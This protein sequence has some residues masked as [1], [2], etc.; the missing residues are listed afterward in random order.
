M[1]FSNVV[2]LCKNWYETRA[3]ER[4]E[5]FW[6]DLA[7]AADADGWSL[8]TK[9]DVSRW[10]L[11]RLDE[12]REDESFQHKYQLTLA[13]F[14]EAAKTW[15]RRAHWQ[16]RTS[17]TGDDAI[18][19]VFRDIIFNMYEFTGGVYPDSRVLPF[20]L[21]D[22]WY[23]DGCYSKEPKL[24]PA[25]M[26]CDYIEEADKHFSSFDKQDIAADRYD[27]IESFLVKESWKDV[28]IELGEDNLNDCIEMIATAEELKN[29][30]IEGI[31]Y[32]EPGKF[33]NCKDINKCEDP[34]KKYIVRLLKERDTYFDDEFRYTLKSIRDDGSK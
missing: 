4:I 9:E 32:F 7:H 11:H 27:E 15:L 34:R 2:L 16:K 19:W 29:C 14:Y 5:L 10:C 26:R 17:F 8:M 33:S 21:K 25:S 3:S 6:M 20:A 12:L 13:S 28:K 23:D 30:E 18:I 24:Y 1:K 22:A 31:G